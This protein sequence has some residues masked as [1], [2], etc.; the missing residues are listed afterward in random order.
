MTNYRVRPDGQTIVDLLPKAMEDSTFSTDSG[1]ESA[2]GAASQ[3]WDYPY[4]T[5]TKWGAGSRD[6]TGGTVTWSI[7]G[8]GW[9]NGLPDGGSAWFQGK[10]V[11]FDSLFSFEYTTILTQAFNAWASVAN[12]NFLQAADNGLNMG[13]SLNANIR[14]GAALIDGKGSGGVDL[15]G[16]SFAPT[17]L[18]NAELSALSGDIILDSGDGAFWTPTSFLA[19]V[20]HEIGHALGLTDLPTSGQIMSESYNPAITTLQNQDIR[21]IQDI[22][23]IRPKAIDGT[24]GNDKIVGTEFDDTLHGLAGNDTLSGG[25]GVDGLFG[26]LGDDVYSIVDYNDSIIENIGEGRDTVISD[27][28]YTLPGNV[29]VLGLAEKGSLT[30]YGNTLDNLIVGN[31]SDNL[32]GGGTGDDVLYGEAGNDYLDG[33]SGN[34]TLFGGTGNDTLV[35]RSGD[36]TYSITDYG[37][38]IIE[39]VNDGTDTVITDVSPHSPDDA[40]I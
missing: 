19:V 4:V 10:T 3:I 2:V 40:I 26:G 1:L 15:H 11:G 14:I 39:N 36:D 23:G 20:T 7:V 13:V 16:S 38:F 25:G 33:D 12:I 21:G 18:G 37:D 5:Q 24:A 28:S 27:V 32:L 30:G 8:S 34:D 35:G 29:E 31:S 17:S 22:Y 9:G 6:T